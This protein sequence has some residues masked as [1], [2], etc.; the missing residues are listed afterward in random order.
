MTV[1]ENDDMKQVSP[2]IKSVY[3]LLCEKAMFEMKEQNEMNK[4]VLGGVGFFFKN[5][6]TQQYICYDK[7]PNNWNEQ[8]IMEDLEEYRKHILKTKG[9]LY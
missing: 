1:F 8:K 7:H 9:I 4:T 5:D 2:I 6:N 3:M